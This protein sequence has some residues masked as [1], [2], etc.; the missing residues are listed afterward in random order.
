[1][2]SFGLLLLCFVQRAFHFVQLLLRFLPR[3]LAFFTHL[4][5]FCNR[6]QHQ[7]HLTLECGNKK[8]MENTGR[9]NFATADLCSRELSSLVCVIVD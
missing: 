7:R 6:S 8:L 1:M 3:S 4:R 2:C 5:R 9:R